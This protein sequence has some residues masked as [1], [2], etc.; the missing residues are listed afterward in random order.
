MID[1]I[2]IF[3]SKDKAHKMKELFTKEECGYRESYVNSI[4]VSDRDIPVNLHIYNKLVYA[5]LII[6]PRGL[7]DTKEMTIKD[8]QEC[9][10]CI[11]KILEEV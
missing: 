8:V 7:E 11:L 6:N 4:E 2:E 5:G 9:I 1:R 10:D 3:I